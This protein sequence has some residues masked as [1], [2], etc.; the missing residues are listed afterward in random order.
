MVFIVNPSGTWDAPKAL[1]TE[2]SMADKRS[3]NFLG[4][5]GVV[6]GSALLLSGCA[7]PPLLTIASYAIDGMSYLSSGKSVSDH[8]LSAV[9]TQDCALF[10][11]VMGDDI[12]RER[13]DRTPDGTAIA[14][15]ELSRIAPAAGVASLDTPDDT[16]DADYE[17][18]PTPAP[19]PAGPADSGGRGIE[20]A[21]LTDGTEVYALMQADGALEVFAHDPRQQSDARS[22]LRMILKVEDYR[23]QP[24]R[25]EGFR[26]NGA[27]YSLTDIVI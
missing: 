9:T 2:R 12:C 15:A 23:D 7:L 24:G 16:G 14:A 8:A 1:M 11:V 3:R 25:I 27:F 6:V 10:R 20:I 21:G 18:A 22:N 4:L 19:I 26:L 13:E 5:S 17:R